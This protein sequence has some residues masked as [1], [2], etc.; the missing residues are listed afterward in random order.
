MTELEKAEIVRSIVVL[1][2]IVSNLAGVVQVEECS[3]EFKAQFNENMDALNASL[4]RSLEGMVDGMD[5]ELSDYAQA[6]DV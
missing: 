3:E 6:R 1:Y 4:A 2:H 5:D